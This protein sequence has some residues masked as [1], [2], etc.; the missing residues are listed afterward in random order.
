[1]RHSAA[2]RLVWYPMSE[3]CPRFRARSRTTRAKTARR[4]AGISA[5]FGRR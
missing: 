5:P 4:L 2:S 1:M 3:V